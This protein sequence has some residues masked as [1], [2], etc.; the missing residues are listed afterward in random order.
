MWAPSVLYTT[1]KTLLLMGIELVSVLGLLLCGILLTARWQATGMA[2]AMVGQQ[3]L[4]I[5]MVLAYFAWQRPWQS[6][7]NPKIDSV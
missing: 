6:V 1:G 4:V 2:I 7:T 3:L 5:L